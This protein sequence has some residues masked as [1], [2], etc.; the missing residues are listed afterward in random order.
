MTAKNNSTAA[1]SQ[2]QAAAVPAGETVVRDNY[3]GQLPA[4]LSAAWLR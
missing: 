2:G 4:S 3:S 1:G